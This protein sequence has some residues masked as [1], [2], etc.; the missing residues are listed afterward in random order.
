MPPRERWSG[1]VSALTDVLDKHL[2]S[3]GW[4]TYGKDRTTVDGASIVKHWANLFLDLYALHANMSFRLGDFGKALTTLAHRHS[5]KWL[6]PDSQQGNVRDQVSMT[7]SLLCRHGNQ[8]LARK[9]QPK[10]LIQVLGMQGGAD[11]LGAGVGSLD[12]DGAGS[13]DHDGAGSLDQRTQDKKKLAPRAH[14]NA[15]RKNRTSTLSPRSTTTLS[16]R[17]TC[18]GSTTSMEGHGERAQILQRT[19]LMLCPSWFLKKTSQRPLS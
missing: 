8:A 1:D 10:W 15:S 3:P 5:S 13:L 19:E 14:R 4:L 11:A 2:L 12:H 6:L 7:L 17:S 18:M 16:L 9:P